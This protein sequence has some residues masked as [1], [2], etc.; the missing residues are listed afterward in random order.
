MADPSRPGTVF[1]AFR[2]EGYD[3]NNGRG[4]LISRDWGDTWEPFSVDGLTCY[5]VGTLIVDPAN[6]S[7]IYAGTGGNGLFR[8]GPAP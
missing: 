4:L 8:Y 5:R 3:V 7:R 1:A 6:P 2:E